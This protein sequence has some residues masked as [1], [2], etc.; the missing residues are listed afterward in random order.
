M[1]YNFETSTSKEQKRAI[2]IKSPVTISLTCTKII[3]S[4]SSAEQGRGLSENILNLYLLVANAG[5]GNL[6]LEIVHKSQAVQLVGE[7]LPKAQRTRGLS[8]YHKFITLIKLQFQNL[9]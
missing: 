6:A 4:E 7:T 2:Q 8:S 9:D 5:D 3:G 1:S